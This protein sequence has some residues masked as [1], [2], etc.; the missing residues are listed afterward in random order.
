MDLADK[1][2]WQ[3]RCDPLTHNKMSDC[4]N[5]TEP[6]EA[7][8]TSSIKANQN[9]RNSPKTTARLRARRKIVNSIPDKSHTILTGDYNWAEHLGKKGGVATLFKNVYQFK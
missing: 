7:K 3:K 6:R 1:L 5:Y 2:P 9:P 8:H 4:T